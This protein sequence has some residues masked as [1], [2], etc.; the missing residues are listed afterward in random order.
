MNLA[1][2]KSTFQIMYDICNFLRSQRFLNIRNEENTYVFQT[3]CYKIVTLV[4]ITR[5]ATAY[6]KTEA[7]QWRNTALVFN[8]FKNLSDKDK[9]KFIKFDI[10]VFYPSVSETSLN[11]S[12]EYAKSFTK[13]E[14]NTIKTIKL[15]ATWLL[16]EVK[17]GGDTLFDVTMGSFDG[18]EL[19]FKLLEVVR[20]KFRRGSFDSGNHACIYLRDNYP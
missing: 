6:F 4:I 3:T 11:K 19:E 16:F 2:L 8:W 17:K 15:A 9:R 10:A 5:I 20:I 14:G 18:A 1:N 7:N 12:I 13:I